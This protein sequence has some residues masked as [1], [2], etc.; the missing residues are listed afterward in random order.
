[1]DRVC[2]G[3]IGNV[4]RSVEV[5]SSSS[6]EAIWTC[7]IT[8]LAHLVALS[9]L[10]SQ[11][12]PNL[13]SSMDDLCNLTL[14]KLGDLS[15]E[16][17]I[18]LCSY[19]DVLTEVDIFAV[20]LRMSK[21]LTGNADQISWKRALDTIDVRIGLCSR[22]ESESL[23]YWRVVIGEAHADLQARLLECGPSQLI[24]SAMLIDGR[25]KD[26]KFP[27]LLVRAGRESYG[28]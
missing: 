9:H 17:H 11:G 28:L 3:L 16:V 6:V 10:L 18:E 14:A 8:C 21:V 20:F 5:G 24:S 15:R 1:M 4:Q 26:S 22:A 12:V 23:R 7:C 19:L 2:D 25:T 13:R 27:N